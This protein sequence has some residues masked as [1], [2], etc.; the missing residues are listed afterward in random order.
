MHAGDIE[1]KMLSAQVRLQ[2]L[3]ILRTV[4]DAL[5]SSLALG[6]PRLCDTFSR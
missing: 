4:S 5:Q 3:R 2:R 1:G 6:P